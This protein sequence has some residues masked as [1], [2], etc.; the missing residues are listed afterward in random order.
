M[1]HYPE[2]QPAKS[3]S[4]SVISTCTC[5]L[6]SETQGITTD[7]VVDPALFVGG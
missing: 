2:L 7:R 4:K 5:R 3:K 1:R 6:A